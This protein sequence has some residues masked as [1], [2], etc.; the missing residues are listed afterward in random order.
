MNQRIYHGNISVANFT[1][2]LLGHFQRG[3]YRVQQFGEQDKT[4]LQIGTREQAMSGGQTALS[5]I[6]QKVE[7]GVSVQVGQQA[8]LGIAASLGTTAISVLRNPWSLVNRLDDLAQDIENLQM[9]DDIWKILNETAQSLG[10]TQE[11]SER[12][13]RIVCTYCDTA[14]PVGEA[15]CIACGAPLGSAQPI[16]CKKCGFVVFRRETKCPN[17]GSSL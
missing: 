17:C 13:R 2:A 7:D 8:W 15:S 9:S 3:N 10:A 6:L 1:S 12:L 16:T 4:I 11:L 14:N 5:I